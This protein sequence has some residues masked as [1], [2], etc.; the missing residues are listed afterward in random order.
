MIKLLSRTEAVDST[1]R[2]KLEIENKKVK[3][4]VYYKIYNEAGEESERE[5]VMEQDM[6]TDENKLYILMGNGHELTMLD[7]FKHTHACREKLNFLKA[8]FNMHF[9]MIFKVGKKVEASNDLNLLIELK[10]INRKDF[11]LVT[12]TAVEEEVLDVNDGLFPQDKRRDIFP[13][14]AVVINGVEYHA[15]DE[16]ELLN[17]ANTVIEYNND[18]IDLAIKKYN[19]YFTEEMNQADDDEKIYLESTCGLLNAKMVKLENGVANVKLYPFEYE[20]IF[21]IK[22]GWRWYSVRGQYD[23]TLKKA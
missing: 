15:N 17:N 3:A 8:M 16:G 2:A 14:Y 23:F 21:T 20:G 12:A 1:T 19:H 11:E 5:L 9:L 18:C 10:A 4:F 13:A 22:I 6:S 7:A